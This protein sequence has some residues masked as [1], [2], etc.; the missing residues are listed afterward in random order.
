MDCLYVLWLSY[1]TYLSDSMSSDQV[2]CGIIKYSIKI[3]KNKFISIVFFK[4]SGSD[5]VIT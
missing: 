3:F 5:M 1:K 2:K 4:L